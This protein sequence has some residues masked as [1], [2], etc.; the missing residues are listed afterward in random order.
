MALRT[1]S[2]GYVLA[3]GLIVQAADATTLAGERAVRD[4]YLGV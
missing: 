2:H 4:A 1:A 3:G